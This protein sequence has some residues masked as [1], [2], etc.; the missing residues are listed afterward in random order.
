MNLLLL[1]A[2]GVPGVVIDHVP[3]PGRAYVGSPSI[4]ILREGAYVASH[5]LFGPGSSQ[6][7][8]AVSRVFRSEDKGRSWRQTA[9]FSDQFWSNLFE[10]RGRLYLM[11]CTYEYGQP[12]IR[13]S[14]DGGRTWSEASV[15]S[16]QTGCHTAPMPVAEWKGRLWRTLEW[17]PEGPWGFF[18][19]LIASAPL[20]ADLMK[21]ESWTFSER[22]K[23]PADAEAGQ[24]WLEGNAV[25]A[26]GG[27]LLNILRVANVE[28]AAILEVT[29]PRAQRYLKMID[30]PGGS[31]KFTIRFD[32]VSGKYWTLSNP[33][34]P[35]FDRPGVNPAM[36]R[37][38]LALMS[39]PD[40]ERWTTERIVLRH[41]DVEKHAFQYVDWQFDGEDLVVASRTAFQDEHGGAHRAHDANF[42][43]FHRV[44]R[45]REAV[46]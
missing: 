33:V 36:V 34:L 4:V 3:A 28:K 16:E 8:S 27:R 13:S 42:L 9:E 26:P 44:E 7:T 10:H 20:G 23:F 45:F 6:S 39:S 15:L 38:T 19:S 30:F 22:L 21:P 46:K 2:L 1:L 40:L 41:P 5:D 25:V 35:E 24:H 37:N 29:G 14:R 32:K 18:E 11:G 17:H 31:K 43:T 12:V